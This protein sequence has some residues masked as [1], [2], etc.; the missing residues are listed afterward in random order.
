MT[1]L[2]AMPTILLVNKAG[3]FYGA[4]DPTTGMP[5]ANG[6]GVNMRMTETRSRVHSI[7]G[8]LTMAPSLA[9]CRSYSVLS[10]CMTR[11]RS[12]LLSTSA[13]WVSEI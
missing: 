8:S 4:F 12:S 5:N 13:C 9:A 7:G 2:D 1:S 3:Q 11:M 10:C 6:N